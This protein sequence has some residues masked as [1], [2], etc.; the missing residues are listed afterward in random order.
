MNYYQ[1][2]GL[3]FKKGGLDVNLE[4]GDL[5][6]WNLGFEIAKLGS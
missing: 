2:F 1:D 4:Y 5:E 6:N 3:P